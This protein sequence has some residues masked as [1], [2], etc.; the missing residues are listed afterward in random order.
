[1][2]ISFLVPWLG[3]T[4]LMVVIA[5]GVLAALALTRRTRGDWRQHVKEHRD[6]FSQTSLTSP[7]ETVPPETV[8]LRGMLNARTEVGDAYFNPDRLPGFERLE[9]ATDRIEKRI[10]ER[11]SKE[12]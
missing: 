6:A 3:T 1:M 9:D 5:I 7:D 2:Q 11:R 10:A 12:R 4:L 8:S